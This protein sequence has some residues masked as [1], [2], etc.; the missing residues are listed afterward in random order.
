MAKEEQAVAYLF[1]EKT[2]YQ[3]PLYQRRYVWQEANW[4]ALWR[5]AI[6]LQGD[7]NHFTGT[8]IKKLGDK[9][10]SYIIVDGQQRLTTF[11]IIFCVIRDLWESGTYTEGIRPDLNKEIEH[12]LFTL[13]KLGSLGTGSLQRTTS[14]NEE[15]GA[16]S[17][18]NSE[19]YPY[20]I[21]ITKERERKAF[22]LVVSGELWENEVKCKNLSFQKAFNLLFQ[23]GSGDQQ[24]QSQQHRIIT[25]YAYFGQEITKHLVNKTDQ[26]L[27]LV[28]LL[29]TLL[30]NFFAVSATLES[31]DRPHQ[32]YRS[33]N[34]TGVALD[35]FDLLR[36][37]LFLRAGKKEKQEELYGEFWAVFGEDG[38]ENHFWEKPGRT[39]QF[40]KDFL[41]AKLGTKTD[42]SKRLFHHVY[43]GAY[44]KTL[45]KELKIDE[46]DSKFVE[47]EFLELSEYAKTYEEMEDPTTDIGR[48][49][50]F[51]KDLN[52]IFENLDLTSIPP[53][54]LYIANELK[55]KSN[56]RDR[57]YQVLESYVLRCQLRHGVN[58]DK[59]TP[60]RI[61]ALFDAIITGRVEIK[62]DEAAE[63]VAKYLGYTR[64]PGRDW[65]GTEKVLNGLRRIPYQL[66]NTSKA[67]RKPVW[68]MLSYIFYRIECSMRGIEKSFEFQEVY[69][70]LKKS[71]SDSRLR[72][73]TL[74]TKQVG[75]RALYS[76][77][78]L[79]F[80][81][82][83]LPSSFRFRD[84]RAILLSKPNSNLSLNQTMKKYDWWYASEI[85]KREK[86]LLT[87]FN[88]IWPP[89]EYFT[90]AKMA[91]QDLKTKDRS[92]WIST[93]QPPF[94][95]MP[96]GEP[97][98]LPEIH[99]LGNDILFMCSS[100]S[101]QELDPYIQI[102]DDIKIKQLKP[103]QQKS[104]QLNIKDEFLKL[105]REE[106]ATVSLVTRYGY[107][108]EGTIEDF[109]EDAICM[110][111]REH[112]VIVFRSGLLEFTIEELFSGFVTRWEPN[113]LCGTIELN[114][115]LLG[116]P[117]KIE[118][119]S[120]SLSRNI[121]SKKLVLN[122]KV[123]FNFKIVEKNG[124]SYFRAHNVV[125]VA[126]ESLHQGKIKVWL[127][128]YGFIES[129]DFQKRIKVNKSDFQDNKDL[130]QQEQQVEF[131]I[132][133][134]VDGQIPVAI[135]VKRVK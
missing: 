102:I 81:H 101:W 86:E 48:R 34:D 57:V 45:K 66:D 36:N 127:G 134:I 15:N 113:N 6:D 10:D 135:N 68:D 3:V 53:F 71:F 62:K 16:D 31:E 72:Q 80:C 73:I 129:N 21:F 59:I 82:R 60:R 98:E 12:K 14:L 103:T 55:L 94:T 64:N 25:A 13:T 91:T 29:D 70:E 5:D 69:E 78:N 90:D 39:D 87:Y 24:N 108:L 85:K 124:K 28:K 99:T 61:N 49:W 50:Q 56:E 37:D 9:S 7:R 76:I 1:N 120:I 105:M 122:P 131:K 63:S 109:Y 104:K 126:P 17:N 30:Y 27:H 11:Q 43:K 95:V 77:G 67:S 133:E 111:I 128:S 84:K 115:D 51:Y 93:I 83:Y 44:Y 112:R 106:Q 96:Y 97:K 58:E 2:R 121:D 89:V 125:N 20:R 118:V 33:I 119:E 75:L 41:M 79:T 117:Q 114:T 22:E 23:K 52:S 35:E 47:R 38:V 40:L 46:N 116:M 88:K 107:L 65:L 74:S 92:P 4:E 54:M 19:K 42:F 32:A 100:E 132:T 18:V 130:I 8:I 123:N 26:H 110:E